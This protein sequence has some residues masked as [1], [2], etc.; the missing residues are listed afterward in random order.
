MRCSLLWFV[1]CCLVFVAFFVMWLVVRL[2]V[3]RCVLFVV[4]CLLLV[5]CDVL[6]VVVVVCSCV[7]LVVTG[8][9]SLFVV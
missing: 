2:G 4:F 6:L 5:A 9:L 1:V 7:L 8:C 3:V